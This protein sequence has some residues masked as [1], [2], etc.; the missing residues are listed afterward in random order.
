MP[1]PVEAPQQQE[2]QPSVQ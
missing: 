1:V 2:A